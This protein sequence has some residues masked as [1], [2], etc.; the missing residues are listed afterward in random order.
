MERDGVSYLEIHV[1]GD[2]SDPRIDDIGGDLTPEWGMHLVDVSVAMGD[3]VD[4]VGTQAE[5]YAAP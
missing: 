3:L 2:P 4:L 1:N 5:A